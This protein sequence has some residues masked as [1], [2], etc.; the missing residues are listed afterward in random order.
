MRMMRFGA[1][2]VVL[3]YS[4]Q[5]FLSAQGTPEIAFDNV[6][7]KGSYGNLTGSTENVLPEEHGV[8]VYIY[9]GG[10]WNKPLN[11]NPVTPIGSDGTWTC[12][13]A[14]VGSDLLATKIAAFLIPED[15]DPP[16][17]NG[18]ALFP[19]GL[20]STAL[21]S[22]QVSRLSP[23]AF[24]FSGYD[25]DVKSSGDYV[26]GPGPNVFSDDLDN[27]WVDAEGKL[28]LKITYQDGEWRCA[29]VIS[30]DSF[31]YGTYRFYIDTPVDDLDPNVVLGLFTWSDD[32][33][34]AYRE[35]DVEVARWGNASDPTNA[36]FVVQ[37]WHH[38]G[39]LKRWTIPSGASPTTYSFDWEADQIY[40]ESHNGAYSPETNTAPVISEWNY[41]GP[42]IPL[43]GDEQVRMNLWLVNGLAP[44]D[45]QEVEVVIDR[46]VFVPSVLSAPRLISTRPGTEGYL[47]I[48]ATGVP[49]IL[50]HLERSE[51][52]RSWTKIQSQIAEE[53][54]FK[55][56]QPM[57]DPTERDFYRVQ[58]PP[59]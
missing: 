59:Q 16:I 6:P 32:P 11:S 35:I 14:T 36:Q 50:Y 55:F 27:V 52:L 15:Y 53:S 4:G 54:D 1:I 19:A 13:I 47:E 39:N 57:P 46:F 9:V 34:Y 25:W 5:N 20:E 42:D 38:T 51:D 31:G 40:F 37:P 10:W 12:D 18:A 56:I 21:A 2:I 29:E 24:H 26:F 43:P 23:N 3:L 48:S 49:Q 33:A 45:G 44:T 28:H 8:A 41:T 17:L 58:V 22:V 30:N 7:A